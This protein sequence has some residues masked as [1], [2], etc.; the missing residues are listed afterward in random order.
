M[1]DLDMMALTQ[2][3][4]TFA[5]R[6]VGRRGFLTKDQPGSFDDILLMAQMGRLIEEV[7]EFARSCRTEDGPDPEELA[8]IVIVCA[9][10][11]RAMKWDLDRAV[12]EK[13]ELDERHRGYR[14]N[15]KPKHETDG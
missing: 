7:G 1:D 13:C 15:G 9:A 8:D 14:H 11:S 6:S 2:N 12:K 5:G 10:I 4:L 3:T